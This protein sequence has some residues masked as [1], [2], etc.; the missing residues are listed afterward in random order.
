MKVVEIDRESRKVA[1][2]IYKMMAG[3]SGENSF[4]TR[5]GTTTNNNIVGVQHSDSITVRNS[6]W[7]R[8]IDIN[9][10][11]PAVGSKVYILFL[12]DSPKNAF[13]RPFNISAQS[14]KVIR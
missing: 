12:D 10:P 13:W 4:S 1:V 11:M 8:A 7:A 14:Y 5:I 3:I 9:N 6:I 2:Y